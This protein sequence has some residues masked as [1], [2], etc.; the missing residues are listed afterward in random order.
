MGSEARKRSREKLREQREKEKRAAKRNR[1]LIVVGAA[2][3]VV[4][5]VVGIGYAVLTSGSSD[6][7]EGP[8]A[9]Q[10]LQDDGSVVM[11][12]PDASAPVVEVYADYQCPACR[13]F[14]HFGGD[15]LKEQAAAGTAI[16]H[17]RPVSIFAQQPVPISSNSLRA[18][19][20]AR[21]AAD[22][23]VFVEYN[24]TLFENQPTEGKDGFTVDEL[25]QWFRDTE[26]SDEDGQ[27]FDD[28]V[29]GEAEIVKEFT[30]EY[31]PAL[32]ADATEQIG[33]ENIGTM[34]LSDLISW[35]ASNGHDP[36]FLEGT[37]TGEIIDATGKA[38]TRYSGANEFRATPSVYINGELLDGNTAMSA[39]GLSD[40]IAE[41]GDGEVS[42]E[43]MDSD[44]GGDAEEN[45]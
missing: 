14:E 22:Y 45:P 20:A 30:E 13:Q 7:Y 12:E 17:Y 15:V 40:A 6:G 26:P 31:L 43:P 34:V 36:A 11:A 21:A 37:Y 29:D 23:G 42:T 33:E 1:T 44:G 32:T 41:A 2:A 24:D 39:R 28:R 9:A 5:L 19:S 16:V 38:Y 35:G 18:G 8:L 4:L 25:K 3:A 27:A 10:T